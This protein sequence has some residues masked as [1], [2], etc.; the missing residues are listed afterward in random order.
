MYIVRSY[1]KKQ[2]QNMRTLQ[3]SCTLENGIDPHPRPPSSRLRKDYK[4]CKYVFLRGWKCMS[5]SHKYLWGSSEF[6]RPYWLRITFHPI[7]NFLDKKQKSWRCEFLKQWQTCTFAT[8]LEEQSEFWKLFGTCKTLLD[9]EYVSIPLNTF[10]L[11][12]APPPPPRK[13]CRC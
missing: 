1:S 12:N 9:Q 5:V 8:N 7:R 13:I 6:W 11:V 3:L 10:L 4:T 2:H